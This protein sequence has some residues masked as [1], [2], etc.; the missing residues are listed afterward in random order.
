V[1]VLVPAQE[2]A[3]AAEPEPDW[4][5]VHQGNDA[6][7][8]QCTPCESPRRPWGTLRRTNHMIHQGNP[9]LGSAMAQALELALG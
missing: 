7:M 8:S 5:L 9:S 6:H 3:L 1:L 4:V 2:L